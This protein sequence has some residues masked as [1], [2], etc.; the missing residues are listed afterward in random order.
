MYICRDPDLDSYKTGTIRRMF[1]SFGVLIFSL[2]KH[3]SL[4]TKY[5]KHTLMLVGRIVQDPDVQ[6]Y[7]TGRIRVLVV[8]DPGIL[9]CLY[10]CL[11]IHIFC[12]MRNQYSILPIFARGG[13]GKKV[14]ILA[15]SK[16]CV[17]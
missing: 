17:L 2:R 8:L 3:R 11:Y 13:G 1:F 16:N 4:I 10:V 12:R 14:L 6:E 7:P 9:I 15:D 5:N